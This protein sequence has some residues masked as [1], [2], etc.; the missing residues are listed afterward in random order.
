[1]FFLASVQNVQ[2]PTIMSLITLDIDL[3]QDEVKLV[4]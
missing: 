3:D 4:L 2:N 1:M